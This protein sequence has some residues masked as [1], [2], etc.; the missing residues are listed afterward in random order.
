MSNDSQ[1]P[2]VRH[3]V[4][5]TSLRKRLCEKAYESPTGKVEVRDARGLHA[6]VNACCYVGRSAI[7]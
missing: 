1:G 7:A 6:E 2:E 5:H 3:N 4:A